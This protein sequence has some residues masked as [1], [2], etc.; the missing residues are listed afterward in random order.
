MLEVKVSK[1]VTKPE[2]QVFEGIVN[3]YGFDRLTPRAARAAL[4]IAGYYT[5]EV[6]TMPGGID[7][8]GIYGYRVYATTARKIYPQF[9]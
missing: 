6:W 3:L 5:G 1:K 9:S 8:Q 7:Y 4:E 2:Y